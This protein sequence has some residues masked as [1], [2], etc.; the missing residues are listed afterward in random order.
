M[1]LL[2]LDSSVWLAAAQ[3]QGEPNRSAALAILD[4][5]KR[6]EV[7]VRL[8]DLTVYELGN[9]MVRKWQRP[10]ERAERLIARVLQLAG[11]PP[12]ALTVDEHRAALELAE[13]HGLSVYD[14][15]YAAVA[16]TRRLTLVSGDRQLLAARLAVAPG[17]A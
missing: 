12:L 3:A 5:R 10:A 16:Q 1:S 15:A 4:R 6:H 17:D 11:A 7:D 9:V 14:A 2:L 13:Q 8:L